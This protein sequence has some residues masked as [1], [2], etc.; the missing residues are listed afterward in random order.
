MVMI[1]LA[2]TVVPK[3]SNLPT[4]LERDQFPRHSTKHLAF[5]P[6]AVAG[7]QLAARFAMP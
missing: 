7:L 3:R 6:T 1:R 2:A 5:R 4:N